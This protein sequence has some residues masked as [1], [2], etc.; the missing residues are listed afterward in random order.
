MGR[1]RQT[2]SR[3]VTGLIHL[4]HNP[5]TCPT[6]L[7]YLLHDPITCPTDLVY[8]LHDPDTCTTCLTVWLNWQ[9]SGLTVLYTCRLLIF[10]C[11]TDNAIKNHWNSYLKKKYDEEACLSAKRRC[12]NDVSLMGYHLNTTLDAAD[13]SNTSPVRPSPPSLICSYDACVYFMLFASKWDTRVMV[14]QCVNRLRILNSVCW[15]KLKSLF[16]LCF[17]LQLMYGSRSM[18]PAHDVSSGYYSNLSQLHHTNTPNPYSLARG[19]E[20][21]ENCYTSILPR[22]TAS[23]QILY[24]Y[25]IITAHYYHLIR[26][27]LCATN[28]YPPTLLPILP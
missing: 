10:V 24:V 16:R 3:Q 26:D 8:L 11:R 17:V 22:S 19:E 20:D 27:G 28:F 13:L 15:S 21:K 4:L 2:S 1:D 7:V 6:G 9:F 23:G 18:H 14:S 25:T 5:D 12:L